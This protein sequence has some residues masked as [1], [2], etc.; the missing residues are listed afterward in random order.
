MVAVEA[1]GAYNPY[2]CGAQAAAVV[3][4]STFVDCDVLGR[5]SR[6]VEIASENCVS[7]RIRI[8]AELP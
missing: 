5:V 1:V 6:R 4:T 7:E 2:A 3:V 8:E